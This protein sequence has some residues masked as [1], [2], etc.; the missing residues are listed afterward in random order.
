[1]GLIV[2]TLGIYLG[3]LFGKLGKQK[4]EKAILQAKLDKKIIEQDTYFKESIIFICKAT[5]QGQCELSEACIRI[6]KLLEYYPD[7][8]SLVEFIVIQDMYNEIK[9]F[10]THDSRKE[11]S[12]QEVFNQDKSRVKIEKAYHDKF[13][14]VLPSLQSQFE[15]MS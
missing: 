12:K 11:L 2:F 1:L 15:Q 4:R 9:D 8:Q 6:K 14:T 13:M 10:A 5:I 3:I 7:V